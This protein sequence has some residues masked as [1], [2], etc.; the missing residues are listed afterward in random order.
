MSS[1]IEE[2]FRTQKIAENSNGDLNHETRH[3]PEEPRSSDK[4]KKF[5][6]S[7]PENLRAEYLVLVE[8]VI[9][10]EKNERTDPLTGLINR[11]GFTERLKS[12]QGR[13]EVNVYSVIVLDLDGF[14]MINDTFGH[15]AGDKCLQLIAEEVGRVMSRPADTLARVG[16]D[17]FFV[18]LPDTDEAGASEVAEKIFTAINKNVTAKLQELYPGS[19]GVSASIGIVS[20][21]KGVTTDIKQE[22]VLILADYVSYVVKKAGKKGILTLREA[23]SGYDTDG[24]LMAQFLAGV[25]L[26]R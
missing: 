17:E 2:V 26:P 24:A 16:G 4:M 9:R 8:E 15:S 21:E 14:K 7:L 18:L 13:R 3:S 10:I 20:Y 6:E 19:A 12:E 1:N 22:H 11:F 5:A 25:Q 23:M